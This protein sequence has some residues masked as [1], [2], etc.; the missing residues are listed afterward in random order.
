MVAKVVMKCTTG[1][2]AKCFDTAE[3]QACTKASILAFGAKA[4]LHE[5]R[6]AGCS[7]ASR[8]LQLFDAATKTST[9][10]SNCTTSRSVFFCTNLRACAALSTTT[11]TAFVSTLG[12]TKATTKTAFGTASRAFFL[13]RQ[14]RS[15]GAATACNFTRVH[16]KATAWEQ[17][18]DRS[19]C[20]TTQ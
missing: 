20:W 15:F 2:E 8:C 19:F 13:F 6:H 17:K 18:L 5:M 12:A 1:H 11:R 14:L 4:R 16:T 3:L 9:K 7:E 10:T